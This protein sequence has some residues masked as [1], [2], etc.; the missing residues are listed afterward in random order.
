[1]ADAVRWDSTVKVV[2]AGALTFTLL[3]TSGC[4]RQTPAQQAADAARHLADTAATP[5]QARLWREAADQ[6]LAVGLEQAPAAGGLVAR[7]VT[8]TAVSQQIVPQPVIIPE[9]VQTAVR[10]LAA[11]AVVPAGF[12][13][14]ATVVGVDGYRIELDFG[15]QERLVLL[16][17]AGGKPIATQ[18]RDRV[19]VEYRTRRDPRTPGD[20][21]AI[22]TEAGGGIVQAVQGG[23]EWVTLTVPL[24]RLT[25]RQSGSPQAM[26]VDVGVGDAHRT[27]RE[28]ETAQ[29]GGLNVTVIGSSAHT[30]EAAERIE[31]SAYTLNLI[32]WR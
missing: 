7:R 23:N 6:G 30:G 17:R 1:M 12:N 25:A 10:I 16:A 13:G 5:D 4:S 14:T 26:T 29:V 3:A 2:I 24:F 8:A 15:Q 9:G 19:Q 32:A 20:I 28:G 11:P 31:G 27:M 18:S 21:L 22:R